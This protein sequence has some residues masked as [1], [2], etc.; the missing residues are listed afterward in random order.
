MRFDGAIATISTLLSIAVLID[1]RQKDQELIEF[2]HGIT[3]INQHIRPEVIMPR[4]TI[5]KWYEDE[6]ENIIEKLQSSDA[7]AWKISLLQKIEDDKLKQM[8]LSAIYSISICDYKLDDEEC[9]FL[10]LATEIWGLKLPE[11]GELERLIG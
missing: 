6:K 4:N 3:T 11:M 8:I 9:R 2:V 5:L 1:N 10:K 7:K